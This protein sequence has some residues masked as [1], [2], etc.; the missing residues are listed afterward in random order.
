M[1]LM[2]N[3]LFYVSLLAL[4]GI[5]Y[6]LFNL[7]SNNRTISTVALLINLVL[8]QSSLM[9]VSFIDYTNVYYL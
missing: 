3:L 9:Y 7:N 1:N 8:F 6:S 5:L 4:S 2:T